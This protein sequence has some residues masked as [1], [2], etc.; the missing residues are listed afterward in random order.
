MSQS[1]SLM[2]EAVTELVAIG[3]AIA[4][5]C[6]PCFRHH[7]DQAHKLGVANEDIREAVNVALAVKTTPQR[8][9]METADRYLAVPEPKA[10]VSSEACRCASGNCC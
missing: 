2:T 4:A 5:S 7:Y 3:A 1:A 6:E 9:V 8:K 10:P